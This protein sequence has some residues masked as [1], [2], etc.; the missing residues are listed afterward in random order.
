MVRPYLS[1]Q[2]EQL[3]SLGDWRKKWGRNAGGSEAPSPTGD[4]WPATT[5]IGLRRL[6]WFWHL[7]SLGFRRGVGGLG[8]CR[9]GPLGTG[10]GRLCWLRRRLCCRLSRWRC[11]D[12]DRL[13]LFAGLRDRAWDALR[14]L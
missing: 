6:G 1:V 12:R 7:D 13:G 14:F 9:V 10:L 11:L 5:L 8:F 3:A 2:F 4:S